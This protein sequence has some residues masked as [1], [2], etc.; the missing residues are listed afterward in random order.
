MFWEVDAVCIHKEYIKATW[1]AQMFSLS[2][3]HK[4]AGRH[5]NR[6]AQLTV[7]ICTTSFHMS[8]DESKS[9][10]VDG[11]KAPKMPTPGWS[12]T[13][14]PAQAGPEADLVLQFGNKCK[15]SASGCCVYAGVHWKQLI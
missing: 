8:M 5:H 1:N 14:P 10:K 12:P 9:L 2:E 15:I 4:Y 13:L 11:A 7:V 6:Y 3:V